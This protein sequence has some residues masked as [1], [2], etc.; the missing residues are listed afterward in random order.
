[1]SEF[2]D[3]LVETL[4]GLISL[5][6]SQIALLQRHYAILE[7]WNRTLNLTAVRSLHETVVR[8]YAESLFLGL[9][10]SKFGESCTVVD[11]GSGAG[12]PGFPI[13]ALLPRWRVSLV[14]SHQRKAVFLRESTRELGNLTVIS[15]RFEAITEA[16]DVGLSRAVAWRDIEKS[17]AS[18]TRHVGLIASASD[19]LQ[20]LGSSSFVWD[21]PI[22]PPW[23]PET[24][25]ILGSSA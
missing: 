18:H 25:V 7:R 19:A 15:K 10:V 22:S 6:A 13:A 23:D 4:D 14:E 12:F 11:I 24:A 20:I 21:A 2:A 8:H 1:M 9:Q 16:F 5:S 3:L 17:V